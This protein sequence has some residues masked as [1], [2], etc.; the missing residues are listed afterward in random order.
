MDESVVF[1]ASYLNVA[2]LNVKE[3]ETRLKVC[4]LRCGGIRQQNIS[5]Y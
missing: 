1:K 4:P 2:K 5:L 3:L